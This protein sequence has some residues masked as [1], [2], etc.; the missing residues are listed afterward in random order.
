MES[1]SGTARCVCMEMEYARI[2][3]KTSVETITPSDVESTVVRSVVRT[4][5][6]WAGVH[7]V[8]LFE[9]LSSRDLGNALSNVSLARYLNSGDDYT[10]VI[11]GDAH[12][13][14]FG[15]SYQGRSLRDVAR[16]APRFGRQLRSSYDLVRTTRRPYA[17]RGVIGWDIPDCRFAHFETVYLPLASDDREITYILNAAEYTPRVPA[18]RCV[19]EAA[20]SRPHMM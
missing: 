17:F 18:E 7:Q 20:L 14:A 13:Q 12:V 9:Q 19:T 1:R 4:W 5:R 6:L 2:P 8:P 3:V 10:F 16:A 11:I 15:A